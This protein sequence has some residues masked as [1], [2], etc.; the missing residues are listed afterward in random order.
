MDTP[1]LEATLTSLGLWKAVKGYPALLV[2]II[3]SATLL[4]LIAPQISSLLPGLSGITLHLFIVVVAT[5]LGLIGYFVGDFWDSRF[6]D[7]RYGLDGMWLN[8]HT[9]PFHVFPAGSD[10]KRCRDKAIH[11]LFGKDHS[12]EGIYRE[13]K[14]IAKR[15]AKRWEQI[16]Q[17][18]ILSKFARG[19]IW[20]CFL[21][22]VASVLVAAASIIFDWELSIA[23]LIVVGA[24]AFCF[25]ALLFIPY[26]QLRVEHMLRLYEDAYEF[27]SR[28][29]SS[30]N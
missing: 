24:I 29:Q 30:Q 27:T 11:A 22:S 28:K 18:L 15:R 2:L 13:A 9:R 1:K 8:S 17:P 25:G 21:I 23:V 10:L 16:E 6:F 12:G 26:F 3:V 19:F 14:K 5:L 4:E 20:P 7:P